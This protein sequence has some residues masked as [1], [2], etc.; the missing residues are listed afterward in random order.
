MICM[1]IFISVRVLYPKNLLHFAAE[2]ALLRIVCG[3]RDAEGHRARPPL[4]TS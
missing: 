4:V 1:F 3:L 2:V